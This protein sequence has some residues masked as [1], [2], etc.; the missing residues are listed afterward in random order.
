MNN[1]QRAAAVKDPPTTAKST[2]V[3]NGAVGDSHFGAGLHLDG[4]AVSVVGSVS[5]VVREGTVG[6]IQNTALYPN[7]AAIPIG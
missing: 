4:A 5:D 1:V 6:N 2:V 3:S 7:A